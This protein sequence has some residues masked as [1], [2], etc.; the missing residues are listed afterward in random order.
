MGT[1][2]VVLHWE[3]LPVGGE[4]LFRDYCRYPTF[5]SLPIRAL[6]Q[7]GMRGGSGHMRGAEYAGYQGTKDIYASGIP[8]T[9]CEADGIYRRAFGV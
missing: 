7:K 2:D 1:F 9:R 3:I 5:T 4:W 6:R 8:K